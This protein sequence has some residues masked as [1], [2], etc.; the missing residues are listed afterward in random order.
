MH[1]TL[2]YNSAD[3][4]GQLHLLHFYDDERYWVIDSA[5]HIIEHRLK[6]APEYYGLTYDELAVLAD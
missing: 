3:Q 4:I 6:A 2:E 5:Y 1:I